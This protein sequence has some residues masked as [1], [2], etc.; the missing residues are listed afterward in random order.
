VTAW[1]S[2]ESA[3]PAWAL[4]A[5]GEISDM[6]VDA[7]VHTHVDNSLA[8]TV[9]R[10][11]KA[12]SQLQAPLSQL[13]DQNLRIKGLESQLAAVMDIIGR[14]Q[15]A[16]DVQGDILRR[17]TVEREQGQNVAAAKSKTTTCH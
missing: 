12:F 15:H 3:I 9:S 16:V 8:D 1:R 11:E 17:F 13:E 5:F 6:G 4:V 7:L 2:R 14:L 10:H